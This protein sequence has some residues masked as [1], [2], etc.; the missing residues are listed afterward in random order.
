M[1]VLERD[2]L[3]A[4]REATA[5]LVDPRVRHFWDGARGL[6]Y[7]LV[8]TLKL[9]ESQLAWDVY[10][11]YGRQARWKGGPLPEPLDWMHQLNVEGLERALVGEELAMRVRRELGR[12]P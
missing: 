1:P 4:A 7:P 3:L 10:L 8:R 5:L 9:K 2:D 11:L 6:G 12:K